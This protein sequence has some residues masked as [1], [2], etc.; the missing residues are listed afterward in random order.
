MKPIH[1]EVIIA[2]IFY[3]LIGYI[4]EFAI[5]NQVYHSLNEKPL[6]DR[7]HNLFPLISKRIPDIGLIAFIL[8]FIFRWSFKH[9]SS[10]VNYLWIITLLFVGRVILLS[11]TQFPPALPNCSSV[12]SG[13][14]LHFIVFSKGWNE[15][16]DYMYSGHTIHCVLIAL[17][18]LFLS[19]YM[20]EKILILLATLI[21]IIF[22]LSSRIHYS[23]DV[24]VGTL[25]TILAFFSWP[26][27]DNIIEHIYDGG[28]YGRILKTFQSKNT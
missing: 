16:M 23:I 15:C 9:P 6:F 2:I 19:P 8:Y 1:K 25:V 18:T 22:I 3:L 20:F 5:E 28:I 11:V 10:L 7:F 24:F 21:E 14:K 17:F 4:N 13:D 27:I 12:K 26:G